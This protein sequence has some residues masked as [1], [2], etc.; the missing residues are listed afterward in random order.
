MSLFIFARKHTKI[1]C[2]S[3]LSELETAVFGEMFIRIYFLNFLFSFSFFYLALVS[4][5]KV[6]IILGDIM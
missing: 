6:K 1:F 2:N 5:E 3:R 4:N